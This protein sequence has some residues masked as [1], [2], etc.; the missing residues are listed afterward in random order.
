MKIKISNIL[1]VISL[2][3]C[4]LNLISFAETDTANDN[5]VSE[6]KTDKN[7]STPEDPIADL[8]RLFFSDF[9]IP[10][11]SDFLENSK[12]P[13][14]EDSSENREIVNSLEESSEFD[15]RCSMTEID[16]KK[17]WN[18]NEKWKDCQRTCDDKTK[19]CRTTC[20]KN[21]ETHPETKLAQPE[22]TESLQENKRFRNVSKH[23][24]IIPDLHSV[25]TQFRHLFTQRKSSSSHKISW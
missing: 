2:A 19:K 21:P 11:F 4:G 5:V 14:G 17:V 24:F 8:D 10:K 16:G 22:L 6:I 15:S 18:C 9:E 23:A 25:P 13:T 7:T 1:L 12:I 3:I 20:S